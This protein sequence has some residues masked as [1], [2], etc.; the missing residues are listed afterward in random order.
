MA[1]CY[2]CGYEDEEIEEEGFYYCPICDDY[3]YFS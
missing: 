2:V 1:T 3:T